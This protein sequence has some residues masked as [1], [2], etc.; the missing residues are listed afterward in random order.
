VTARF[1]QRLFGAT[2]LALSPFAASGAARAETLHLDFDYQLT[3]H[4]IL[5][6]QM[7]SQGTI[8]DDSYRL[9]YSGTTLGLFDI[10]IAYESH[11]ESTGRIVDGAA[12]PSSYRLDARWHGEARHVSLTYGPDGQIKAEVA[13]PPESE[14]IDPVPEPMRENTIDPLSAATLVGLSGARDAAA[15]CASVVHVFDGRQRYDMRLENLGIEEL[16]KRSGDAYSGPALKCR[17]T[18][19]RI[20]GFKYKSFVEPQRP[21]TTVWLARFV[22]GKL[23][24]PVR[25]ATET[26]LG[27]VVGSLTGIHIEVEPDKPKP[28]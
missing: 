9:S 27:D 5:V 10:L 18:I 15:T 28:P 20:A 1:S 3:W 6:Y 22:Q 7:S 12:H 17:V 19:Q 11:A 14:N 23:L 24:L 16:E 2:L 8:A 13:P 26:G 4:G 25:L 21:P